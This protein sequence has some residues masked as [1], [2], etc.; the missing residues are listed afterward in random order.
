[1]NLLADRKTNHKKICQK[2]KISSISVVKNTIT[3]DDF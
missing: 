1:M 3:C 2:H